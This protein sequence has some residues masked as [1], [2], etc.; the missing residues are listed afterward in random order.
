MS[1]AKYQHYLAR[2][3]MSWFANNDGTTSFWSVP[4]EHLLDNVKLTEIGGQNH[5][6]ESDD[7][8]RNFVEREVL[9]KIEADFF[10]VRTRII[11][12]R[13]IRI[14]RDRD[15]VRRYIA[16]QYVRQGY[17]HHRLMHFEHDLLFIAKEMGLEKLWQTDALQSG[18]PRRR[19]S[20]L[21][22]K[23][24]YNLD[25]I[26][27][28]I[29]N[30]LVTF[31]ERPQE[32]LLLP[33]RGFVQVFYEN[34]ELR[35]DGLK[36]RDLKILM[37][38]A[39]GAALKL[40]PVPRRGRFSPR[41]TMGTRGYE[42]FMQ[43]LKLNAKTF[44]V[45]KRDV[46]LS[47]NLRS[48]PHFDPIAERIS[49]VMHLYKV[50]ALDDLIAKFYQDTRLDVPFAEV[51]RWFYSDKFIPAMNKLFNPNDDPNAETILFDP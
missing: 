46:I 26:T 15:V 7:L 37:P 16:A 41:T 10:E 51:R 28:L 1:Y 45:G 25:Q 43:N 24:L 12:D 17:M 29:G 27:N 19:A 31:V 9:G 30:H 50:G 36:S 48:L 39:P 22:A 49:M 8:P 18:S 23:N 13:E 3:H 35:A 20:S 14:A 33:D 5:L 2:H 44:I 32:D 42:L 4:D 47:A 11:R 38:I 40:V 6:Y 21:I 34:E